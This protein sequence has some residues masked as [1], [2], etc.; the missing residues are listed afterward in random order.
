MGL[1]FTVA[2]TILGMFREL[3]GA[4]SIFGYAIP[5]I[6][7]QPV[8]IMVLAPGAFFVLACLVAIQN[9]I[10][11]KKG[12]AAVCSR[13]GCAGCTNSLCGGKNLTQAEA[14]ADA[15]KKEG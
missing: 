7:D 14:V 10:R 11:S 1:G 15:V 2:L 13:S 6:S 9:K 4:G 5:V 3:I 8:S 12:E